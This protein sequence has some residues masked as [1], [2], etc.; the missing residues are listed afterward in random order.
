GSWL[1]AL[2]VF[3]PSVGGRFRVGAGVSLSLPQRPS[4][5]LG[6]LADALAYP[7]SAAE[8]PR[9]RLADA[10]RAVGL[11]ELVDRLGEEANWAQ[12]L[13]IGEQQRL[14]FA[15]VLLARPQIVFFYAAA[16]ALAGAAVIS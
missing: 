8:Q 16:S 12:R 13:S 10:L 9:G 2:P 4:L 7:R 15:R 14:A 3:G 11:P 5:P 1:R 6:T